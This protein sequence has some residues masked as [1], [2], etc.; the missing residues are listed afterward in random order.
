[1][2]ITV[3]GCRGSIPV[4]DA[5]MI[6]CGGNTTCLEVQAGKSTLI[7]DAGTGIRKLGE[8]LIRRGCR[9]ITL[10]ITQVEYLKDTYR[11][12]DAT[13]LR[14]ANRFKDHYESYFM[15]M[16]QVHAISFRL[17]ILKNP[18]HP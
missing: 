13:L 10:A 2:K 11:W 9:N 5:K 4:P 3:W 1:M 18:V 16:Y 8:T 14:L 15:Y 7:I 12:L 17:K 6:S